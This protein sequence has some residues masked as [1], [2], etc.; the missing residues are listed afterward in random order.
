M[1]SKIVLSAFSLLSLL[2]LAEA[3]ILPS[4]IKRED[5]VVPSAPPPP[6][7][8]I[9][10]AIFTSIVDAVIPYSIIVN[11]ILDAHIKDSIDR[12]LK[13]MKPSGELKNWYLAQ[14]N[15]RELKELQEK[16]LL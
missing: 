2:S 11:A 8:E 10:V 1:S 16:K 15:E 7:L 12:N 9:G 13:N 6:D 5:F 14:L 4:I 3:S